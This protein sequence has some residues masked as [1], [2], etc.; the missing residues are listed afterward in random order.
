MLGLEDL[1]SHT[2]TDVARLLDAAVYINI[3]VVDDEEEQVGRHS[4]FVTGLVP[5]LL[6]HL[7]TVSKV[8][9]TH[10][11]LL[12]MLRVSG[13][14]TTVGFINLHELLE[15]GLDGLR[16]RAATALNTADTPC[17]DWALLVIHGELASIESPSTCNHVRGLDSGLL[18][19]GTEVNSGRGKDTSLHLGSIRANL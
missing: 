17:L 11:R 14:E 2:K 7:T 8:T 6:D 4:V 1:R 5:N 16:R 15:E 13:N 9:G 18:G 3:A 12:A 10:P 19:S